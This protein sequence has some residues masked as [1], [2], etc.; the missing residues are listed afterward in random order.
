MSQVDRKHSQADAGV[1]LEIENL[2]TVYYAYIRRL[3]CSILD[4]PGEAEDAAQETFIAAARSLPGFRKQATPKTWLTSI[5]VNICRGRLRRRRTRATLQAALESLHILATPDDPEKI[6]I[7]NDNNR[8]L[9]QAVDA[10]DEKHRLP[11][12]LRYVH[13]LTIPEIA[14][15]LGLN[16]GTVHSRLHYARRRLMAQLGE[17][18]PRTEVK[19]GAA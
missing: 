13:E 12:I 9:W 18:N 4:D 2:A 7:Q 11:V 17:L 10:L 5:A 3:A 6:S 19:D 16:Q 1:C 15:S 14:E 8:L